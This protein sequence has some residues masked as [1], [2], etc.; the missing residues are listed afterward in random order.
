[1]REHPFQ[2][3]VALITGSSRG[4]G[5]VIARTFSALGADVVIT[6]RKEGG[7]SEAKGKRLCNE[8]RGG[9]GRALLLNL[10]ISQKKSVHKAIIDTETHFGHLDFLILNAARAPFKPFERLFERELRDLVYTNYLGH[11][12]CIQESISLLEKTK[13]KIVFISSLG[14]RFHNPSYPLGSMKAAM[15]S[16]VRDCSESLREKGISV[17]GVCGGIARTDS[18][19]TL[20]MYWDGIDRLPEGLFVTAEEIADVVIFLCGHESR[21]IVGQTLVV[22]KGL[23]NGLLRHIG[24]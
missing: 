24:P 9:G 12:F 15:E 13:G 4:I 16:V 7:S 2:E 22:D 6:H 3:K 21:G 19:K 23:S 10:D 14:S 17:N 8:I 20:R 1:M 11:I 18:F 5:S